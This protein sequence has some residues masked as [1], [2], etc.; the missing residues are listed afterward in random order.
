MLLDDFKKRP[1]KLFHLPSLNPTRGVAHFLMDFLMRDDVI[2]TYTP[3]E[4]FTNLTQYAEYL[5]AWVSVIKEDGS[6]KGIQASHFRIINALYKS[7]F[8]RLDSEVQTPVKNMI[9]LRWT[10]EAISSR[11]KIAKEIILPKRQAN[12]KIVERLA[13]SYGVKMRYIRDRGLFEA[14][15]LDDESIPS[16]RLRMARSI[17]VSN[18]EGNPVT[19]YRDLTLAEW[20]EFLFQ[21]AKRAGDKAQPQPLPAGHMS[22]YSILK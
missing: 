8:L 14:I 9:V 6:I 1:K 11:R 16:H 7:G 3:H 21:S 18:Q 4:E 10:D 5:G 13:L 22:H 2:I 19:R 12:S 20:D 17:P 15:T